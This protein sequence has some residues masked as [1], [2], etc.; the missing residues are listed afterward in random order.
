[1]AQLRTA[2][3]NANGQTFTI[4]V[5][6]NERALITMTITSTITVTWTVAAPGGSNFV[7]LKRQDGTTNA[8]YTA[9]DYLQVEGP[10]TLMATASGVTGGTCAIEA[11]DVFVS[12]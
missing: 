7:A 4:N 8:A 11:R 1:M 12:I 5:S 9:S 10:C 2:T 6:G 3:L